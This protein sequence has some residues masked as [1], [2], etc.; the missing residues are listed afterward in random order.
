METLNWNKL[1]RNVLRVLSIVVLLFY[2]IWRIAIPLVGGEKLYL[3]K[4]D[5]YVMLGCI[6][7]LLAIEAVKAFVERFLTRN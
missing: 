1:G 7:L 3:D 4:N 2:T 6:A 5:G